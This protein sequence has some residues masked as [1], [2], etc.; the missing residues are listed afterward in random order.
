MVDLYYGGGEQKMWRELLARE[1]VEHVSL[2]Y[3]GLRRRIKDPSRW[4]IADNFPSEQKIY[5]DAGTH[6]L[7][8]SDDTDPDE[9]WD[10][11]QQYMDFVEANLDAIAFASEFDAQVLGRE[12]IEDLRD[13]RWLTWRDKW[14]PIWHAEY[15]VPDLLSMVET[16]GRV[17]VLQG[18]TNADLTPLLRKLAG[19]TMLHGVAMTR[20]EAMSEI[21]WASVG[22]T[23][24]LHTTYSRRDLRVDGQGTQAVPEEVQGPG[25][26]AP[27]HLAD[28]SGLQHGADRGRR[29][30]RAASPIHLVM[31]ATSQRHWRR[32]EK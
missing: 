19:Q 22:S 27:P 4:R 25:Q 10:L 24:W 31:A 7:N 8:K 21:P 13:K 23:S 11:A 29:Q 3:I 26:E 32:A 6:S 20:M 18:D 9:A 28:R 15:G 12:T 16:Y 14:M 5:L 17:G 1:G 2:S 30:R